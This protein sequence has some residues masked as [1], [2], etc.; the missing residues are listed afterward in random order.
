[1]LRTPVLLPRGLWAVSV[2]ETAQE[3]SLL[4]AQL[5][6][7]EIVAVVVLFDPWVV[8]VSSYRDV[9]TVRRLVASL[10]LVA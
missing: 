5:C 3:A 8:A 9:M 2:Y 4:V 1:M 10:S 7:R 6:E